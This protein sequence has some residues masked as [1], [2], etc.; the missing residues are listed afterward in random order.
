MTLHDIVCVRTPGLATHEDVAHGLVTIECLLSGT[1]CV[2]S[3]AL[4]RSHPC[5]RGEQRL[6]QAVLYCVLGRLAFLLL[7]AIDADS[8]STKADDNRE[9]RIG[10][11]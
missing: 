4:E 5:A 6:P 8:S 1:Q 3:T 10:H 9:D 11:L 7:L 2:C